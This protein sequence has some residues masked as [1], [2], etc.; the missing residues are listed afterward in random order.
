MPKYDFMSFGEP[1][2]RLTPLGHD[3]FGQTDEMRLGDVDAVRGLEQ[4]KES[5]CAGRA[6]RQA[7]RP[8]GLVEW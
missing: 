7:C 5:D 2:I 4:D 8:F 3:R 1:N 6:G